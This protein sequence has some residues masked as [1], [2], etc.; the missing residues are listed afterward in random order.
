MLAVATPH[1]DLKRARRYAAI[2]GTMS[3]N[4]TSRA[5][6]ICPRRVADDIP[7]IDGR[8]YETDSDFEDD[9]DGGEDESNNDNILDEEEEGDFVEEGGEDTT[10][11]SN[12]DTPSA[13]SQDELLNSKGYYKD[14]FIPDN[15]LLPWAEVKASY[16]QFPCPH[17]Y[18]KEWKKTLEAKAYSKGGTSDIVITCKRCNNATVV[19]TANRRNKQEEQDNTASKKGYNPKSNLFRDYAINFQLVLLMQHLGIGPDGLAIIFAFFGMAASKGS[20]IK[21]KSLQDEIGVAEQ[22]VSKEVMKKNIEDESELVKQKAM[23]KWEEWKQSAEGLQSTEAL[24]VEKMRLLLNMTYHNNNDRVGIAVGMDGAW[25]RRAIGLGG[26]NSKSGMNFCVG[27]ETSK[28]LNL[29]VLSKQCS[30][31]LL[32]TKK[33]MPPKEHRCSQNFNPRDSSKSMEPKAAKQHKVD[34]ETQDNGVYIHTLL[35]DDDSTVR[36]NTKWSYKAVADRD[37]PG[38]RRKADTDWPFRMVPDKKNNDWKRSYHPDYGI[39][40]LCCFAIFKYLSDIGHRVK[41]IGK[42]TFGMK[43]KTKNPDEVG[44]QKW[45]CL[46]LKKQAGYYF[47]KS[48]NQSLSFVEFCRRAPCIY[49]HHFNDHSCCSESWC[50]V[51]KSKRRD[52]PLPLTEA[53]LRQFRCMDTDKKLFAKVKEGY[54]AYMTEEALA[55]VYHRYSTNKNESLN[56]KCTAVAPKDRYFSGTMSLHDRF[57]LVV[58]EDSDGCQSGLD[59]ILKLV[60]FTNGVSPILREWCKRKDQRMAKQAVWFKK[61]EVKAR[62]AAA[63]NA[64]IKA[65]CLSDAKAAKEGITYGTGIAMVIARDDI[66]EDTILNQNQSPVDA[67]TSSQYGEL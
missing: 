14:A 27:L 61:P 66:D 19:C 43:V 6:N 48:D 18:T 8:P 58:I 24:Q 7:P 3:R 16:E 59:R 38:W 15:V 42:V 25:Q 22:T 17:C 33:G 60:G 34:I 26:G 30:T 35:T 21:W 64:I 52:D 63:I 62:R 11:S 50:K 2:A 20:Y 55:Q 45:E 12:D 9:D 54:A 4:T 39:L 1:A 36:A 53:Y 28:I 56:R 49:L 10:A 40:P 13:S 41:C 32:A 31:C 46:K 47:K 44:L 5:S 57:A 65:G 51:L 37:F 23:D 67:E 29:V